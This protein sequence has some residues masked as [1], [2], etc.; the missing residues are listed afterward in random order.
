M[1]RLGPL[2]LLLCAFAP[3]ECRPVDP[4]PPRP[5]E[6]GLHALLAHCDE[7]YD[8]QRHMLR[9]RFRN[10]GYHSRVPSGTTVHPTRES[11]AYAAALLQRGTA[12]DAERAARIIRAVLPL[13][14][15][16]RDSPTYGAWPWLLEEPLAEMADPDLNWA[17]FCAAPLAQMLARHSAAL[18]DDLREDMRAALR[19]AVAAIRA[20]DVGPGYTNIA[21]LGGG[22]CAAAGEL[23][24]DDG[25]LGYGR[26]RLRKVVAHTAR[27]GSFNE[28]NSPPYTTVALLECE[29]TLFLV[30]DPATRV[31][32]N[33]LRR[34]AWEIIA[35]SFHPGTQQWAGPHSRNSRD[36]LRGRT[37]EF[38]ARRTGVPIELHPAM[39]EDDPPRGDEI[40]PPLPC[41]ADLV[42]NF[43]RAGSDESLP[44]R[45]TRQVYVRGKSEETSTIGTAWFAEDACLGSAN[46]STLWTQR[47]PLLGYWRTARDPAVVFRARFLHDGRDFASMGIRTIQRGPRALS[48]FGSVPERGDWHPSLD[49][50][51]EG[52]FEARSF[53]LRYELS[54]AD[55]RAEDLGDGRVALVAGARRVV[56]H[57]GPGRF[58][59]EEIEWT[60]GRDRETAFVEAVCYQGPTRE[61]DFSRP[62]EIQLVVGIELLN[63]DDPPAPGP[64]RIARPAADRM[65]ADWAIPGEGPLSLSITDT[66]FLHL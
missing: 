15:A 5:L 25:L 60:H 26:E 24:G 22:V 31:A 8:P 57:T 55:V 23:L 50:P 39:A 62:L 18:P 30:R 59:G 37:V 64:P 21:V 33:S 19:R 10:P 41:P 20:R 49:R 65:D 11:L 51:A 13:Q 2:I 61:F 52:V 17:D 44:P 9:E 29:R 6:S 56:I 7:Q 54:G 36:R 35:G 12:G 1:I 34:T 42:A 58:A 48:V 28:Y 16:D 40:V 14:D 46:R 32:A 53:R 27:H 43:R 66:S 45:A 47:R 38:L 3:L 63:E 4:A